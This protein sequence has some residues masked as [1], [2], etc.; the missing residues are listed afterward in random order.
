MM[1]TSGTQEQWAVGESGAHRND[2]HLG[3]IVIGTRVHGR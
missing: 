2:G 1:G 3:H